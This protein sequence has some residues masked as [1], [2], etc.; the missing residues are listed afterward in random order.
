MFSSLNISASGLTAQRLRL[1]VISNNIANAETT[2][3]ASGGALSST[4]GNFCCPRRSCFCFLHE[5]C[6][7][8]WFY[9]MWGACDQ[10]NRGPF[11]FKARIS[12]RPSRC[13]VEGYVRYPNVNMV[14][15]MVD[16]ISASRSYEA[17]AAVFNASKSMAVKALELGRR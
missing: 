14:T 10:N 11:S 12:T 2:R 1:D 8:Y 16:M 7:T 13:D 6:S 9:W 3:T 15:E 17:N 5:P 4:V